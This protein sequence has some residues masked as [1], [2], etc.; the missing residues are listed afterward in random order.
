MINALLLAIMHS[1]WCRSSFVTE[2][3]MHSLVS[4]EYMMHGDDEIATSSS[5]APT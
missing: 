3:Y 2:L 5:D 1:C 4:P